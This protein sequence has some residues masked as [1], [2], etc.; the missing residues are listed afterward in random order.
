MADPSAPRPQ[1]EP[2]KQDASSNVSHHEV[3][4]DI[5]EIGKP[6]IVSPEHLDK[7]QY[8][9]YAEALARYPNDDCIDAREE[10]KVLR[11]LDRRIIPLLGICYFFYYVDKT[12]L[13]YAAIFGLKEDL[14]LRGDEYSWL[15]GTRPGTT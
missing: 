10:K 2:D 5:E 15:S 13:S 8:G 9:I 14:D 1:T 3:E 7:Q 12:T 4:Q 11:K 6:S